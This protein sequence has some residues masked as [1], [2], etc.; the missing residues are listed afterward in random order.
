MK[1]SEG[2]ST[3][4]AVSR[5]SGGAPTPHTAGRAQQEKRFLRA[6]PLPL[7]CA[8]AASPLFPGTCTRLTIT[9]QV[10]NC[11]SLLVPNKPILL[12]KYLTVYGFTRGK[13]EIKC[14]G[15]VTDGS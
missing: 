14:W 5:Q 2:P 4:T 13:Q 3:K 15:E 10:P 11:S 1:I 6:L 12:E 9:P 8:R 7:L